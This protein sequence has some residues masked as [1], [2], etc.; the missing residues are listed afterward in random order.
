[1]K[2]GN[3]FILVMIVPM[4]RR[5]KRDIWRPAE[6]NRSKR[7]IIIAT[8]SVYSSLDGRG[9]ALKTALILDLTTGEGTPHRRTSNKALIIHST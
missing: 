2:I 3:G 8:L 9:A 1:M 7:V 5:K 6:R 4:K